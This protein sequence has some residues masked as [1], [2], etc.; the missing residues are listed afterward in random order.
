[1]TLSRQL[2]ALMVVTFLLIFSGIFWISVENTRSYLMLQLATQTQN[3]ADA[4]GLSLAPYMQQK[5][6]AAMDTMINAA[7]DSAYY[8]SLRLETMQ[9][10]VLI[11]RQNTARIAGVP[12]WFIHH[13]TLDTPSAESVISSGWSQ[14]GRL[15][16]QAHPGYAYK[17]LWDMTVGM[18]RWSLLA[19]V[20]S[21]VA[22]LIILK[23]M[24]RP[25]D[26]VE[27][28]ALAIG[29]GEF[30]IV[31]H[32]PRTRELKRVVLAMNKMSARVEGFISTLSQR[33]EQLRRQAHYDA[34]TGLM[35]RSGFD[36]RLEL[37]IKDRESAGS[38]ALVV[39]RIKGLAAYNQQYGHQ[40]G[41]ELLVEI[42]RLLT[43]LS[44]AVQAATPARITGTDFAVILPLADAGM[45]AEFAASLCAGLDGLATTLAVDDM[46]HAGIAHFSYASGSAQTEPGALLAAADA[47]LSQ[48]EH[49]GA[50]A[51]V[52]LAANSAVRGNEAW[53]TLI[54]Q[55]MADHRMQLLSQAVLNRQGEQLY[56]EVLMRI[57]DDAGEQLSPA[58]F[59]SMA[60][61]LDLHAALDRYVIEQVTAVLEG[62]PAA[63]ATSGKLGINIA[64]RSLADAGFRRWLGGYFSD[65]TE[66]AAR[67]CFEISE[68]GLLQ[69]IDAAQ[70]F[71]DLAHAYGA[72]VV[73]EHFGARMSSFQHLSHLNLDYI[74]ID[75][76]YIRNIAEHS[77]NRFFLQTVTDIAHGLDM[78]V[79]AEHVESEADI[80]TLNQIGVNAMQGYC[81]GAPE[82]LHKPEPA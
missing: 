61:R 52:I 6:I 30:P 53:K 75:G 8:K 43:R 35:N 57:Q 60:E 74:K 76:S 33:A 79:I 16:L 38:G 22:V 39:L 34:L 1:M 47:A 54:T 51:C 77:D 71:I 55:A 36:A 70:H 72:A 40:A 12:Q 29:A 37:A 65:H 24:L 78:Q 4:L 80:E 15:I 46:A 20:L 69:D 50:N 13:L 17:K 25:L 42:G 48:A 18:L 64:A 59:A 73:M 19:F 5:D 45:V 68:Y 27:R 32:I 10:K 26:A 81:L 23:A 14:S 49:Q 44:D 7:F 3:A 82:P 21:L 66:A 41:S 58:L 63:H 62:E 11:E 2:L 56:R 28:Q 9:G 31:E 67:I